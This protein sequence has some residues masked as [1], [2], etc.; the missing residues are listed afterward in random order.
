MKVRGRRECKE[1]GTRWSYYDTGEIACPGCGSLHSVGTDDERSLHTATAATLDLSPVRNAIDEQP[2]RRLAE[3][4]VD[5]C[6]EFTGGYGFIQS[7]VLQPLD[8]TY[9]A[10]MELRHVA[11]ELTRRMDST[12]DEERYFTTLL[13]ADDDERPAI[14]EVPDSLRAM[15]GLAYANAVKEYRSDLRRYLEEHPDPAVGNI[16]ERL[17]DHTKRIRAL[18]GDVSPRAVESLVES[19]RDI[20]RYLSSGEESAL[21]TAE[22]RLDELA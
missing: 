9:L 12:D 13:R 10:A 14:E 11:G 16:L 4:A 15:R 22:S 1:C 8:D 3:R 17:G 6:R 2:T 7:G 19:A 21:A 5:R 18:D 20:G